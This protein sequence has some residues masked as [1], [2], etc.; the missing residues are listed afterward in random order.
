M[1]VNTAKNQC[2]GSLL[3]SALCIN[4]CT[5]VFVK[6]LISSGIDVDSVD[7][8]GD[9]PLHKAVQNQT[10]HPS[11]VEI[12]L[13][14]GSHVN[15]KNRNG[16][17]PLDLAIENG[18]SLAIV[19]LLLKYCLLEKPDFNIED[20]TREHEL[21]GMLSEYA[22][23]CEQELHR[24]K[25]DNLGNGRTLFEFMQMYSGY[26][27]YSNAEEGFNVD[28]LLLIIANKRYPLYSQLISSKLERSLL[29]DKL[30]EC[31]VYTAVKGISDVNC[32][33]PRKVLLNYDCAC[34]LA[35]YLDQNDL[36]SVIIAF[37]N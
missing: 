15:V 11:V 18:C 20:W 33:M 27:M 21:Q 29:K 23:K 34:V 12:L 36:L 19:Q 26:K 4:G 35:N 2:G 28:Q 37:C 6:F 24:M 8:F 3:H 5:A 16:L 14:R 7:E 25:S 9:T 17:S 30:E 1:N 10:G 22:I 32:S 31:N 13:R